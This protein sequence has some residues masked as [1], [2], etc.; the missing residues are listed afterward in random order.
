MMKNNRGLVITTIILALL[1]VAVGS[2][3]AYDTFVKQDETIQPSINENVGNDISAEVMKYTYEGVKGL[4]TYTSEAAQNEQDLFYYLYLYE[5]GMFNYKMGTGASFGYIGNYVIKEDKVVLNFLFKIDS[6]AGV[7]VSTGSKTITITE[8]DVLVDDNPSV[9]V[10]DMKKVTLKKASSAEEREFLQGDDFLEILKNYHATNTIE[11]D[12]TIQPSDNEKEYTYDS[13]KGLYKYI[14]ETITNELGSEYFA[15]FY[16]HLYEN[17]TFSYE[18]GTGAPW[19]YM[20]NYIIEGNKI[21]L[22]YLFSTDSGAGM[23]VTT[24]SKTITITAND[25]L[26]DANPLVTAGNIKKVTLKKASSAEE[27]EFLQGGGFSHR[28]NNSY[29]FNDAMNTQT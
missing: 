8:N 20:G 5:N 28:L 23:I 16:L 1:L 19:G 6:G 29:I 2:Y 22:N 11:K 10:D 24:G 27:S 26:V 3:V 15:Y 13:V 21:V 18:M 9:V 4:Y 17:G 12:E 14:G 25:T 7:T